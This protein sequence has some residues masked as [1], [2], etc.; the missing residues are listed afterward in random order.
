MWCSIQCGLP[1]RRS[2]R[3]AELL[4]AVAAE[5]GFEPRRLIDLS[6]HEAEQ[7]FLEGT[8]DLVLDHVQRVAY[9]CRSPRTNAR[10]R[11]G[12]WGRLLDYRAA[13]V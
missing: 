1:N 9:A 6:V 13:A 3:R 5:L 8:G 7:R 4:E 10:L 2:E 11:G 12:Q